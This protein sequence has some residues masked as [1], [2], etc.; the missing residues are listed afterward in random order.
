LIWHKLSPRCDGG[1]AHAGRH[2]AVGGG[3]E[4][5]PSSDA[6]QADDRAPRALIQQHVRRRI[7][8]LEVEGR[9]KDVAALTMSVLGRRPAARGRGRTVIQSGVPSTLDGLGAVGSDICGYDLRRRVGWEARILGP[10]LFFFLARSAS[11]SARPVAGEP[12]GD[13]GDTSSNI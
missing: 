4:R 8:E 11:P 2:G 10:F 12:L 1:W 9:R 6:Q 5:R 13:S 3:G 7:G